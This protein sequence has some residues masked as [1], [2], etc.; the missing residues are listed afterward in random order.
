MSRPESVSSRM[1]SLGSST[2]IWKISL[3]F[4]SP[5]ENPSLTGRLSSS[6]SM[7]STFIFSFTSVRKSIASS[8]SWPR[9]LRTALSAASQEVGVADAGDFDRV[10]ESQEDAL[11]RA[12]LGRHLK[13]VLAVERDRAGRDRVHLAAGEHLRERAL[14]RAVRPH[15][16][17]HLARVDGQVD[18]LEDLLAVDFRAKA[19]DF[20][21]RHDCG[22]C[23]ACC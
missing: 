17:V 1:A 10:L 8:S 14:A 18:P 2:A 4:F 23:L 21:K 15:D 16:G 7:S 20:E 12:L 9:C 11:A 13:E 19:A 3:R 6:G 5:P 22:S